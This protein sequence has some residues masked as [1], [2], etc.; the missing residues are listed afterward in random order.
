MPWYFP[1]QAMFETC[2]MPVLPRGEV[3]RSLHSLSTPGLRGVSVDSKLFPEH[4]TG[5]LY[6]GGSTLE[7]G[8]ATHMERP[9]RDLQNQDADGRSLRV[10]RLRRTFD[11]PSGEKVAVHGLDISMYEGQI[12]VL[13]GHNG[14]F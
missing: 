9:S 11:T 5:L 4:S 13:L 8:P 7:S 1:Y 6:D 10:E 14:K 2:V 3:S 12:F